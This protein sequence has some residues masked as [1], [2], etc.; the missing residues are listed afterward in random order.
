[1]PE[2]DIEKYFEEK[3]KNSSSGGANFDDDDALGKDI[4]DFIS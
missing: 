4:I 3:Y 2:E 1:M